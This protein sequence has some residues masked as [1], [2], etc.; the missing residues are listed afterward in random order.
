MKFQVP[1]RKIEVFTAED[2]RSIERHTLQKTIETDLDT[3]EKLDFSTEQELYF[4]VSPLQNASFKFRIEGASSL[5]DAFEKY[6]AV[7][8]TVYNEIQKQMLE[9]RGSIQAATPADLE[10][11]ESEVSRSGKRKGRIIV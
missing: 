4:G 3:E 8:E 1:I 9:Q 7:W 6:I 10:E 2:G 11:I 5:E